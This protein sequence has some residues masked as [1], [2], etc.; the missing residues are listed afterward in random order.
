MPERVNSGRWTEDFEVE[1]GPGALI[2]TSG[3]FAVV[4]AGL[5]IVAG[6]AVAFGGAAMLLLQCAR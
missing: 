5:L 6:I 2:P 3:C 1:Y 4:V